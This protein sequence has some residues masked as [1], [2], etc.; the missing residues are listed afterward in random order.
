MFET[1]TL[2]DDEIL[3]ITLSECRRNWW[4]NRADQGVA[5]ADIDNVLDMALSDLLD[6]FKLPDRQE[7]DLY[8]RLK[9]MAWEQ[10]EELEL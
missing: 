5:Y 9:T 3:F 1:L 8:T 7:N 4:A 10:K 6:E 2:I